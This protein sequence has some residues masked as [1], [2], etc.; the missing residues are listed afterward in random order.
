MVTLP[1]W[2]ALADPPLPA[3]DPPLPLDAVVLPPLLDPPLPSEL[4]PTLAGLAQAAAMS[5]AASEAAQGARETTRRRV[6]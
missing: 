3:A 5:V 6:A 4:C 1:P 2:P